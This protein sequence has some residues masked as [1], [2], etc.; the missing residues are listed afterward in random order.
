MKLQFFYIGDLCRFIDVLLEA[1]P[2]QHIFN[3]G[4]R[5][6]VSVRQWAGFC[7]QAAGKEASFVNVYA[8]IER[9]NY[10]SFYDYEYYPDVYRQYSLMPT[11]TPLSEELQASFAWYKDNADKVVRKP[12]MAYIDGHLS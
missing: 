1:R 11:V 9:R 7:Y 12:L 3:V 4:N 10:F 5:E 6:P 8:D 2:A